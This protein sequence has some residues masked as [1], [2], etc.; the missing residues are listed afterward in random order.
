MCKQIA[1]Y[2]GWKN[3]T[4]GLGL[5]DI[6]FDHTPWQDDDLGIAKAYLANVIAAVRQADSWMAPGEGV[7]VHNSGQVPDAGIL[8]A[9]RSDLVVT[10]EGTYGEMTGR[11]EVHAQVKAAGREREEAA[12][13]V[14]GVPKTLGLGGLRRIIENVSRDVEWLYVTDL[15]D[16]PYVGYGS[17]FERWLTVAW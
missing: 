1:T 13:L 2:A 6:Y 10:F 16:G 15:L 3:V 7:V 11:E 12:M 5:H 9:W 8:L 14:K 4:Q 17:M